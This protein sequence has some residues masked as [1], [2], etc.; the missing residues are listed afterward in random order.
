MSAKNRTASGAAGGL[1]GLVGLSA[2]AGV[3]V[4]AAVTPALAVTGMAA[5]NSITMF[6]S[7]PG[8]LEIGELA[9]K[10]DIYATAAD[11]SPVHLASFYDQDREEVPWEAMSQYLKDAAVAGEDPRFYEHGGVDVQGTL[12]AALNEYVIGGATQGGSSITQQYVKNV[13]VNNAVREHPNEEERE[14]AIEEATKTTPDRKLKEIR[15]AISIEKKYPKDE[16]LRGYLNI[17][18]FGGRVYGVESAAKYYFGKSAADVSLAEAASLIAMTNNPEK[19]RLDQPDDEDNGAATVN[20]Q[21]EPEPYAANKERRDYILDRML[22]YKK[23]TQE[24]HDAAIA[25]PVTPVITPSS[26]GCQSAPSGSGFFCDYVKN[27]IINS[28]DDPAT[29]DVNEGAQMLEQG[30]LQ[31]YTTLDL[32]LQAAAD[33]AIRELV[34]FTS[35]FDVGAVSVSVQVGTGRV[36]AMAQNKDYSPDPD[37]IAAS[38]GTASAVNY[39]TDY[40]YGGSSGFQPGSTY[41]IFTV[42]EWLAEG[43]SLNESVDGRRKSNWGT[44]QDSCN[45]PQSDP[46]WNPKN[47]EGGNGGSMT[48][49]QST[50]NSTNTGFVGMAKELDLCGIRKTAEAFGVHR[51]DGEPLG[52]SPA[53]ILGT[54]E[55]APVTMAAAFAGVGGN[56]MVCDP[57]AIDKI[58]NGKGEEVAPPSANCSQRVDPNVTAG[59]AYAMQRVMSQGTAT[60]S[61]GRTEPWVPMAGKTGT[62]DNN[63]ATWMSGTSTKVATV[64]G[65]FNASGHT[66]LRNEYFDAGQVAQIRHQIWPRVMSVANA[67]YG[68]DDFPDAPD[69]ALRSIQSEVPNVVGLSL[70]AAQKALEDAGF[71]FAHSGDIDSDLPAGT[72]ATQDPSGLAGKGTTVNVAT[73]NGQGVKVP[74][75]TGMTR[76]QAKAA[77]EA[78][79]LKFQASGGGG[80][81]VVTGQNPAAG[82]V[83]GKG[84]NVSVTMS[85][86]GQP[87]TPPENGEGDG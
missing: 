57:I 47:D 41:K 59:M 14:A 74:D 46:S 50:I 38:G 70:E 18:A 31:V 37:V 5:N 8:Y 4:T 69:G 24:D 85:N 19:F 20:A 76:D 60:S 12:R 13:L 72:V 15:Y 67:K 65:V 86:G 10:S 43:H 56:G 78:A 52:Q 45:G 77:V 29:E 6:E 40:D 28:Y 51:A 68:G 63:E 42:G 25:T 17:A 71:G 22:E 35:S 2:L 64:A 79:G 23:I 87:S 48:A 53:T 58:I 75:L 26:T 30:G 33:G 11:G 7:L 49:L 34:P 73:S 54:N 80:N 1:L 55:I 82:T 3:L 66:N 62:S 81:S 27:I 44:F 61:N 36:L 39:N 84:G 9:Q 16:I 32:D 83:V 21:G